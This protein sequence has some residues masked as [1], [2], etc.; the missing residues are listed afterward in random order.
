MNSF[1]IKTI[2]FFQMK[3]AILYK[4]QFMMI[5]YGINK[6]VETKIRKAQF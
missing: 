6:K 2:L 3:T 4:I 5:V 1:L